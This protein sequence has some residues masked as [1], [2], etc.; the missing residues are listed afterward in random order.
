MR[1]N[2]LAAM[3]VLMCVTAGAQQ[4]A[5]VTIEDFEG[6]VSWDGL[7]VDTTVAREGRASG[8]WRPAEHS[9]VRTTDIPH[10]W[11]DYDLLRLWLYS[12]KANGQRLTL[13]CDSE[14][15]ADD[16]GWD[17]FYYHFE[18]NWKG[19][20]LFNLRLGEDI[21]PTRKPVG[22][23][24]INYLS[25]NASGW[26]HHPLPDT[27]LRLDAV[28][29]VRAPVRTEQVERRTSVED[30]AASTA[31]TVR[32]TNRTGAPHSFP[33]RVEGDFNIFTPHLNLERTPEIAPGESVEVVVTLTADADAL[34]R[35]EPLSIE[36]GAL[37]IDSGIEDLPPVQVRIAAAAPLPPRKRPL[38]FASQEEIDRAQQRAE[39]H[40]W[41]RKT[42]AGIISRADKALDMAVDIP[43]EGG[44][45]SHHYVCRECGVGLKTKS[46][47]EHVCPRC[48]KV[49]TGW[50]YDQVVVARQ[51]HR[52]TRAVFELG[53]GYAFTGNADYARKAREILLAY[54][55]RYVDFPIHN[56]RGRVS[57]S[58]GRLYA[59]TLDE[60][61]DIIKVA[62]G[63]DLIYDSGVFSDEDRRII[64]NGYLREVAK[65]IMR[66]DAGKSNWQSWHNAGVAAIG[67]CLRDEALAAH[68]IN[69]PHGLRYQLRTSILPDGFWYEGT[70]AYHFYA[71]D[72]LRWTVEAAWHSGMDLYDDAAYKSMYDA[73]LLYVFPD[74]KFPAVNDSDVFSLAG[75]RRLYELAYARWRDPRYLNVL[76]A[77]GRGGLEALLWGA[78]ELSAAGGMELESHDFTGLGAAVLRVGSGDDQVY[79]HLDYGPHGG[80]HG[81]PDK[82]T[83]ILFA[84]GRELAPDPGRLAYGAPLHGQWYRQTIAHNTITVDGVSQ[85]PATGRLLLFHDGEGARIVRAR[86]DT[87]YPGVTMTRTVLLTD[88]Y[89]LDIF[90]VASE[91]EHTYDWAWHNVG[92][93]TQP[94]PGGEPSAPLSESNGYQ[95]IA[96]LRRAQCDDSWRVR[97]DVP[98][99]GAVELTMLGEPGTEVYTGEGLL[100]RK[101]E[102]CPMVIARRR[103]ANTTFISVVNWFR[104]DEGPVV[105]AIEP[106]PVTMDGQRAGPDEALGLRVVTTTGEDLM[107][108]APDAVG[109][110]SIEDLQ[111]QAGIYFV[112]RSGGEIVAVEHV[113]AAR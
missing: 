103:C 57:R 53:L 17:Y 15:E 66:N 43:A 37:A 91:D 88:R 39:Q 52:L 104:G 54:G 59:Q 98:D 25:I 109:T 81:H 77:T 10:N 95:H 97:F 23:N 71:L 87:A 29:L 58:G 2:C 3:G 62:W 51:H 6:E 20:K 49:Y 9:S 92:E 96:D 33:L 75:Q 113:D 102:R 35:A 70:A 68:A 63:Y 83:L 8:L 112:S 76:T 89:L 108:L 67:F 14:N 41:A 4:P 21:Q 50:P 101:V 60:S 61:V 30:G 65:T 46:P 105:E 85:R 42:L 86:C 106:V 27:L 55:E 34:S 48:G 1:P 93:L 82:L 69:G 78:D 26:Q 28:R 90:E 74:L 40:D 79:L 45:W 84:L 5:V 36:E 11:S 32:I 107:L 12:E 94:P 7:T 18:V 44:Q 99:T 73:P 13:V 80:G 22:W 24:H 111:T 56:T 100:G 31:I 19:W 47:T 64:E 16:T 110:K 38:L 72:A